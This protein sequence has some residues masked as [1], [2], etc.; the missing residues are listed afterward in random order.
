MR[1]VIAVAAGLS[2]CLGCSHAASDPSAEPVPTVVPNA[3]LPAG[4]PAAKTYR[5]PLDGLPSI[6]DSHALV[7]I[8][9]FSDYQCPYSRRAEATLSQLLQSYGRQLRLVVAE[10]PLPMHDRARP[11]AVAALAASSQGA[12]DRMRARLFA[13][14]L[15]D[16]AI[17]LAAND[18]GLDEGR[19]DADRAGPAAEALARS[20]ALAERLGVRGT[21]TFF[22]NGR[23]VVGAQPIEDLR[24]VID[25]RLVAARALVAG[26]VRPEDVYA[27]AIAGGAE[28]VEEPSEGKGPGCGGDGECNGAD[29][30]GDDEPVIGTSIETVPTDGAPS[31]G[32]AR[33]SITVVEF[34]DYQC[35]FCARAEATVHAIEQAHPGDV[36]IVFKNLP[37]P[38]HEHARLMAR[39]AVA[40]GAQ[41][42]FWEMHDRL[43]A[44]AGTVDR[45][46]LAGIARDLG[47]DGARF[48]RDLEDVSLDARVDAD[49]ADAKALGVKGTPTFF[50]N[51]RRIVGAQPAAVFEKAIAK[52]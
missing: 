17:A 38:I 27:H 39:A 4:A 10:R 29:G 20:E 22:I 33:A 9:A 50:V 25:E 7:T 46:R 31:R 24:S 40:A 37:L 34:A 49:D 41:G 3:E 19:F 28:R 14:P 2:L 42:H 47:L 8:V 45:A 15:D 12:F 35:P 26:G 36:R 21:P 1:H 43:L 44:V 51:G 52:R 30:K 23:H 5:V 48:D 6:G 32:P 11:A 18:L 16:R 13:G